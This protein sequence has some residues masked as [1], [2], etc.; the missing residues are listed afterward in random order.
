[1]KTMRPLFAHLI[2]MMLGIA[3]GLAI[4][5]VMK[6]SGG[7]TTSSDADRVT[8]LLGVRDASAADRV[9]TQWLDSGSSDRS[10][11]EKNALQSAIFDLS[12]H[13]LRK[14][15]NRLMTLDLYEHNA[16]FL[17]TFSAWGEQAP[18][19][20]LAMIETL[21]PSHRSSARDRV[22]EAWVLVDPDAAFAYANRGPKRRTE[23]VGLTKDANLWHTLARVDPQQ[24]LARASG[25]ADAK[26]RRARE[27]EI[28]A[29]MGY[30]DPEGA[31]NWL[32]AH[33]AGDAKKEAVV[34]VLRNWAS[35]EPRKAFDYLV[36]EGEALQSRDAYKR[37]GGA[38]NLVDATGLREKVPEKY[39][40][41][42]W[43]AFVERKA[44]SSPAEAA[45][46]ASSLTEGYSRR[47]AL[48][49]I[50]SQWSMVDPVAASEWVNELPRSR[51]RDSA[52][53]ALAHQL[54]ST[55]PEAGVAWFADMDHESDRRP[56]L[57]NALIDWLRKD[58]SA[59]MAWMDEQPPER[60]SPDLKADVLKDV[61]D[62]R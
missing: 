15:A 4:R 7:L 3:I 16:A 62:N 55:D 45:Q 27:D 28:V 25:I 47:G 57:H 13:D 9:F 19:E 42:F 51:S 29:R 26:L 21:P 31:M 61:P 41:A 44:Y 37:I 43:G 1:M 52:I 34:G 56:H 38:M 6:P 60:V 49:S 23:F 10:V 24:A 14:L 5:S 12:T 32:E 36:S 39:R 2:A 18:R 59:A 17:A 8:S 33:R 50:A 11:E 40:N 35:A 53:S 30:E 22:L 46:L 58:R 20:A 54:M 48:Y